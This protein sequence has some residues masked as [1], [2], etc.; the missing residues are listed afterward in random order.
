M[1]FTGGPIGGNVNTITNTG[2][3]K[4]FH[5]INH[6]RNA[7]GVRFLGGFTTGYGGKEI[8]PYSRFYLGGEND[9]RGFD[10]R[11]VSPVTYI[12]NTINQTDFVSGRALQRAGAA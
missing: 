9:L 5:P 1:S 11:A 7:V 8:P 10:I 3:F 6:R 4:Y 12:P 2:E